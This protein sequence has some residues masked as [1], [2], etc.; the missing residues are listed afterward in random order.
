MRI[1]ATEIKFKIT[2]EKQVYKIKCRIFTNKI[3]QVE[4]KWVCQI[5]LV[6]LL[7]ILSLFI[8]LVTSWPKEDNKD[9][10]SI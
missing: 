1:T 9:T 4:E 8:V 2:A 5:P 7:Q 3:L 6:L 10:R